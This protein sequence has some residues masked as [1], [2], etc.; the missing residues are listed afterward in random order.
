MSGITLLALVFRRA[1]MSLVKAL[2]PVLE[3]GVHGLQMVF[4]AAGQH[5]G[6]RQM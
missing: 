4:F 3:Q 1:A 2:S 5:G 6:M